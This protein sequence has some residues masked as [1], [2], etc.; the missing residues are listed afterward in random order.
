MKTSLRYLLGSL[1]LVL[2]VVLAFLNQAFFF[3]ALI[4]PLTRILWLIYRTLLIVDQLVYWA[5]LVL[6]AFIVGL[7][8]LP[9]R[10]EPLRRPS[11]TQTPQLDDRAAY[12]EAL[13]QSAGDDPN[14]RLALQRELEK[15]RR[16]V[17]ALVEDSGQ[18][19]ISLPPVQNG[20]RRR[21]RAIWKHVSPGRMPAREYAGLD[22]S[23]DI[24]LRSM[25]TQ[26]EK[27]N[28]RNPSHPNDD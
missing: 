7:R 27:N 24:I 22:K 25:E 12:W 11:E 8:I 20:L 23:V 5:L 28:D 13:L 10:Q 9:A 17:E 18:G 19:E 2:L 6:A 4:A 26:L 21:L 1:A 16:S 15:L 14:A 3:T